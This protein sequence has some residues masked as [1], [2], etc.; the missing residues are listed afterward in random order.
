M[1]TAAK[2]DEAWIL[3]H[4]KET[5]KTVWGGEARHLLGDRLYK[6]LLHEALILLVFTQDDELVPDASARRV[7]TAGVRQ[8]IDEMEKRPR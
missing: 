6:A 8:I 1:A 5:V 7:L 3:K 2:R 4:C